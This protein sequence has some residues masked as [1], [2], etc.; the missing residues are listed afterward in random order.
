MNKADLPD[1]ASILSSS[2]NWQDPTFLKGTKDAIY[3][4]GVDRWN[5]SMYEAN[6]KVEWRRVTE[7]RDAKM[8]GTSG[9]LSNNDVNQGAI[10]NCYFL[11]AAAAIA[12][13]PERLQKIFLNQSND[14]N[15]AGIYGVNLYALG[16]P[17]TVVIDDYLPLMS[18]EIGSYTTMFAKISDD[19]AMWMP[20]LE[21]A[22][23][24]FN[25]NY[26]HTEAGHPATA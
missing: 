26:L 9:Q 6:E 1:F 10:G 20:I 3:W 17:I 7:I 8:W 23:A 21:K 5:R 11:A 13:K 18:D 14:L 16:V 22:F 15:E 4:D 24:K 12:E 19:K 2:D 25:G